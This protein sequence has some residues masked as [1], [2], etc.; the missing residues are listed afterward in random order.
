[1]ERV[2]DKKG[3]GSQPTFMASGCLLELKLPFLQILAVELR[4]LVK[5]IHGVFA[6]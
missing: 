4:L 5:S 1:M 3:R 2:R 6:V